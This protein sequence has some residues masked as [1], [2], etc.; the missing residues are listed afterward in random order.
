MKTTL[1]P[2][3]LL[4]ALQAI[5]AAARARAPGRNAPR[6]STSTCCSTATWSY[7]RATSWWCRIPACRARLRARATV[8]VAPRPRWRGGERLDALL[9]AVAGQRS[10]NSF[11]DRFDSCPGEDVALLT[12]SNV[13]MTFAWYAHLKYQRSA[14]GSS[15]RWRAGASPCSSTCC[16]S[17]PTASATPAMSLAQLKIMQ[18]VIT[19]SVFVPFAVFFMKQPLKLDFLWAALCLFGAVYFVFRST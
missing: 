18:E 12:A 14:P 4:H 1:A 11:D 16:R 6:S 8:E 13:F 7:R 2:H 5:E 19:L 3:G 10:L 9:P 15:P 17:R